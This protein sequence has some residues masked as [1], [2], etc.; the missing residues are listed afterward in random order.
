MIGMKSPSFAFNSIDVPG[1]NYRMWEWMRG[2][3]GI[4]A[5]TLV[6]KILEIDATARRRKGDRLLNIIINAHGDSGYVTIGGRGNKEL[7]NNKCSE[8]MRLKGKNL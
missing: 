4:T 7:N 8:Y 2:Y 5:M 1:Q 6:G 3:E